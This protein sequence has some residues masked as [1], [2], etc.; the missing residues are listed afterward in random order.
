MDIEQDQSLATGTE[1]DLGGLVAAEIP[2]LYRYAVSIVGDRTRAEDLVGDTVVRALEHR[3][4]TGVRR[5]F[6]P[7][8]TGSSPTSPSTEAATAPTR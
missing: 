7:G 5:H 1:T 4:S 3:G 8:C 2:G 6:A